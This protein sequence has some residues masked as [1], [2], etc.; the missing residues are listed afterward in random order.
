MVSDVVVLKFYICHF[1]EQPLSPEN[2]RKRKVRAL[3][4]RCNDVTRYLT[5]RS[6]QDDQLLLGE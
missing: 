2:K 1:T 3:H 4:D 6:D 5:Q